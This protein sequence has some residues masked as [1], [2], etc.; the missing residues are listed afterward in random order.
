MK[1]DW[2]NIFTF[3]VF[4]IQFNKI[5]RFFTTITYD[6]GLTLSL[7]ELYHPVP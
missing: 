7:I 3:E 5:F 2:R 4:Y 6:R 1:S